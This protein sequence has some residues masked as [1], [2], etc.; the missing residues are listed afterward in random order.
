RPRLHR[1]ALEIDELSGFAR[2]AWEARASKPTA[3]RVFHS[4]AGVM[5]R[6]QKARPRVRIVPGRCKSTTRSE[7]HPGQMVVWRHQSGLR[8]YFLATRLTDHLSAPPHLVRCLSQL[9][10][11]TMRLAALRR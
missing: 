2:L 7:S 10:R 5:S 4:L 1:G 6:R 9:T 8:P 11:R 3:G